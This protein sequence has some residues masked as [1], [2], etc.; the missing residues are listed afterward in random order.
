MSIKYLENSAWPLTQK[1]KHRAERSCSEVEWHSW[2]FDNS[3]RSTVEACEWVVAL[4]PFLPLL[5]YILSHH[6]VR[7]MSGSCDCVKYWRKYKPTVPSV[8]LGNVRSPAN[9][10]DELWA[11]LRHR[12]EYQ[13][14]SVLASQRRGCTQACSTWLFHRHQAERWA[15]RWCSSGHAAMMGRLCSPDIKPLAVSVS[16]ASVCT[17]GRNPGWCGSQQYW[18]TTGDRPINKLIHKTGI[19]IGQNL[20]A[21]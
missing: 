19:I 14:C 16:E 2:T 1:A 15:V 6:E 9:E 5:I 12:R 20:E 11:Q 7:S 18:G 13:Q 3:P 10:M 17:A 21:Y 8:I 4:F